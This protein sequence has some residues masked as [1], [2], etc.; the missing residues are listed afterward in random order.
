M[1]AALIIG[2]KESSQGAVNK[3]F[4]IS[5]FVFNSQLVDDLMEVYSGNVELIKILRDAYRGLPHKV[6]EEKPNFAISF[7]GPFQPKQ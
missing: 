2:H 5:E 4:G 3:E 6:N 7:H 1:K